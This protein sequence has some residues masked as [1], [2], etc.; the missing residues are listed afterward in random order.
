MKREKVYC[1]I[2]AI[3]TTIVLWT[4]T[5]KIVPTLKEG[6]I[7]ILLMYLTLASV[8]FVSGSC[9]I[10][11]RKSK[12]S[13]CALLAGLDGLVMTISFIIGCF[14]EIDKP[15]RNSILITFFV[16]FMLLGVLCG[17]WS[18]FEKDE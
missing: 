15:I 7:V 9:I 11:N 2:L 16:T 14:G 6:I 3:I 10:K 8:I 12:E 13:W 4:L 18:K 5:I 17:L 1:L